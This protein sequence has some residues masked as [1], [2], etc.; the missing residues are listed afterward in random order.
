MN[1]KP[2][3]LPLTD[4]F[5][6][7]VIRAEMAKPLHCLDTTTKTAPQRP[8]FFYVPIS[9]GDRRMTRQQSNKP[10]KNGSTKT[11]PEKISTEQAPELVSR[12]ASLQARTGASTTGQPAMCRKEAA[13]GKKQPAMAHRQ[14]AMDHRQP[15]TGQRAPGTGKRQPAT[16]Y[17][18]IV[19]AERLTKEDIIRRNSQHDSDA[20]LRVEAPTLVER[21]YD[22]GV[23]GR[24]QSRDGEA[25]TRRDNGLWLMQLYDQLYHSEGVGRYQPYGL[26]GYNSG[27]EAEMSDAEAELRALYHR[28]L[29][30]LPASTTQSLRFLCRDQQLPR[31]LTEP[32]G[33]SLDAL[34]SWRQQ[35]RQ[36]QRDR[37]EQTERGEG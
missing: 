14:T 5:S 36:I 11:A 13:I 25:E 20:L 28:Y 9:W 15:A 1:R 12:Q 27:G 4:K 24:K 22:R 26:G 32:L 33:Q 10:E 30:G 31:V 17:L 18:E 8:Q 35:D 2:N 21:L 37:Q 7:T 6:E 16:G 29:R 19:T 23:F 3:D 34:N